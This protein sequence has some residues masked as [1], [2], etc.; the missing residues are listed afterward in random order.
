M[1]E[2]GL[3]HEIERTVLERHVE[4][5]SEL[6]V[7]LQRLRRLGV[8]AAI[9][10][11]TPGIDPALAQRADQF[12]RGGAGHEQLAALALAPDDPEQFH[13]IVGVGELAP[14]LVIRTLAAIVLEIIA[15]DL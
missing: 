6:V 4:D 1:A 2:A 11:D 12:A 7:L 5:R 3:E 14:S 8:N 10:L 13:Q 9:V 15:I